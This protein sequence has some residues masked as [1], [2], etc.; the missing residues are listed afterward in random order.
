[1][2]YS[3]SVYYWLLTGCFLIFAMVIVGGIT[4]LTGSGL[5]IVRWD[6]V[7]GTLPPLNEKEWNE[8][9]DLYKQSP[10]YQKINFDFSLEDFKNIFWWEYIHRLI[11]RIIGIVFIVPFFFFVVKKKLSRKL[12]F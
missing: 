8:T 10:Q 7:T 9:F 5:S 12:I 3:K 2:T 11:G 6:I 4:R 1:M